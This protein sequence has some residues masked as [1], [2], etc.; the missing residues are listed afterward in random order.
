M[1]GDSVSGVIS[2]ILALVI[3]FSI[4][5]A[6]HPYSVKYA[7]EVCQSNGGWKKIEEGYGF[8]SSV[9]C[10]NGAEF[11]YSWTELERKENK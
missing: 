8:F 7:E 1:D 6:V 9:Q 10:N 2:L 4:E 11:E 5:P 3:F